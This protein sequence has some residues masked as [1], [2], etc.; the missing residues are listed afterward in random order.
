MA[1]ITEEKMQNLDRD[2][3]DIGEAGN[4]DKI[5]NPRYGLPFKSLPM[6]SR[7]FDAMIATGYAVIE[8][9]QAAIDIALEAGAGAAGWTADLISYQG[10]TQRQFN[11]GQKLKNEQWRTIKDFNNDFVAASNWIKQSTNNFVEL[12]PGEV[13]TL[14]QTGT[15]FFNRYVCKNG[16]ATVRVPASLNLDYYSKTD[17]TEIVYLEGI[18][19]LVA[20]HRGTLTTDAQQ[21]YPFTYTRNIRSQTLKRL[22]I[23]GLTDINDENTWSDDIG[24]TRM[25]GFIEVRVSEFSY[26]EDVEHYG[27]GLFCMITFTDQ[28][29]TRYE[30]NVVGFNNETNIYSTTGLFRSGKSSDIKIINTDNQKTYWI[31]KNAGVGLNGKNCILCESDATDL[32]EIDNVTGVG[33]IEKSVYNTCKNSITRNI[34]DIGCF[35]AGTIKHKKTPG[36]KTGNVDGIGVTSKN[37]SNT[38]GVMDVYGWN[39]ANFKDYEILLDA[40]IAT[41][42]FMFDDIAELTVNRMTIKNAGCPIRFTGEQ[43]CGVV[44]F[45]NSRFINCWSQN[46][47]MLFL[48]DGTTRNIDELHLIN[49][50]HYVENL[51]SYLATAFSSFAAPFDGVKKVFMD[52]VEAVSRISPFKPGTITSYIKVVNS[53]FTLFDSPTIS[54]M[55]VGFISSSYTPKANEFD[56][57]IQFI[58]TT[59]TSLTYSVNFKKLKDDG[60]VNCADY[61]NQV[62]IDYKVSGSSN[63][64]VAQFGDK[65][66]KLTATYLQSQIEFVY[67]AVTKTVTQIFNVGGMFASTNT[68]NKISFSIDAT[69]MLIINVG[70]SWNNPTVNLTVRLSRF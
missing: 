3:K 22:V 44:K 59:V 37:P 32:Y 63:I 39:K 43:D 65:S 57:S 7:L 23:K 41:Y 50:C 58:S 56:F 27:V 26:I 45:L 4:E 13:Y 11:D 35:S 68:A 66:F 14:T 16:K 19:Y 2:I 40:R 21:L 1:I 49:V 8:D 47:N 18:K 9:L 28:K 62:D 52:N 29:A 15:L 42:P 53:R 70:A 34:T 17:G 60:L 24:S 20:G 33:A 30:K 67:D 54:N 64:N 38:V 25:Q 5:I 69:G 61:W 6:L 51:S 46:T 31:K 10:G 48:R 12:F 55:W 36:L